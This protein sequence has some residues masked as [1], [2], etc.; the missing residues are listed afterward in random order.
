MYLRLLF[1]Q[2]FEIT[3]FLCITFFLHFFCKWAKISIRPIDWYFLVAFVIS[4][5]IFGLIKDVL[6]EKGIF[7]KKTPVIK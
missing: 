5:L 3:Q 6:K 7:P 4:Y 1:N 2:V